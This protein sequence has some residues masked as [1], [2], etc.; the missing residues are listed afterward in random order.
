MKKLFFVLCALVAGLSAVN[1]QTYSGVQ[2]D[3]MYYNLWDYY[4]H[5]VNNVYTTD[6]YYAEVTSN[7]NK[8]SAK[9]VVPASVEYNGQ[10]YNV[11]AVGYEAF[12]DCSNLTS[13]TLPEGITV[14]AC[15]L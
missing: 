7:P 10:T 2:I 14:V 6:Y 4:D 9:V 13:V 5:Y 12:E 8:Y 3:G 11:K 15:C 1:A